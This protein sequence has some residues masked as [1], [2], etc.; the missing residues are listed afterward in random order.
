[1]EELLGVIE[2]E[3]EIVLQE[4]INGAESSCHFG[5]GEVVLVHE[6]ILHTLRNISGSK[7][8]LFAMGIATQEGG[9]AIRE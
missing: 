5:S 8:K 9:I 7:S 1:M 4:S 2:G 6:N 3:V